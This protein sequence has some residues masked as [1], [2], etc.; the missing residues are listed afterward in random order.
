MILEISRSQDS[1]NNIVNIM[2]FNLRSWKRFRAISV[3]VQISIREKHNSKAR[4]LLHIVVKRDKSCMRVKINQMRLAYSRFKIHNHGKM[5][6]ANMTKS[7][8]WSTLSIMEVVSL[9]P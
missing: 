3:K 6:L 9:L 2:N 1:R 8:R 7:S 4:K 5:N